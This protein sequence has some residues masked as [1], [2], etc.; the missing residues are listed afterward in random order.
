MVQANTTLGNEGESCVKS[1]E[2]IA[3]AYRL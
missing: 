2:N 1:I 3:K